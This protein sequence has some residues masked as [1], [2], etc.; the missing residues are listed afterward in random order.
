MNNLAIGK[1]RRLASIF[2]LRGDKLEYIRAGSTFRRARAD[3]M[4]ETAEINAV[5]ADSAGIPH[6]R[7][8]VVFENPNRATVR[9]GPRILALKTFIQMFNERVVR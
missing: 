3:S 4:T 8:D 7:F 2:C 9:E 6:V 1:G 5:Y